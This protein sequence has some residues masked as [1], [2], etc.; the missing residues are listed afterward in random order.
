MLDREIFYTLV[1]VRVLAEWYKQ[2]YNRV[3]PH[4]SMGYR[5]LAPETL[6]PADPVPLLIGVT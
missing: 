2:T 3:R 4:S 1:E 6:M 5:P